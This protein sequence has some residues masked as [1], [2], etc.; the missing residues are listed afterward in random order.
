MSVS[1]D[2]VLHVAHLAEIAV[3][4]A[5]LP[6]LVDQMGRI[7]D[8]VAQLD[9]VQ[10]EGQVEPFLAGPAGVVLRADEPRRAALTRSPGELAPAF[11]EGFFIVPRHGA[12]EDR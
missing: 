12:M 5:E 4:D 11:A 1:R 9:A 6:R 3:S 7:V 10:W 8:Y 2:D